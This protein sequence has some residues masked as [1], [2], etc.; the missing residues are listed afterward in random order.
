MPAYLT[1]ARYKKMAFGIDT[2]ELD[3]I[4]LAAL[5][6]QAT[7]MVNAYC[8]AP[9]L[10]QAH[11]FRGGT[12]T[13]EQHQ[14]RYPETPFDIGQRKAF[15]FHWPIKKMNQFRI[16]VTNTQYVGIDPTEL[17]VNNSLRY[18][19]VV[20][21]ALTSAGL[22]NALVIPNIGLATPVVR[23]A[24]D[25]GWDFIEPGE[26]LLPDDGQ[27]WRAQNQWWYSEQTGTDAMG[28][29]IGGAP[30]ITID[31][32]VATSG[33]TIDYDEGT[34]TLDSDMPPATTVEA[35]YHYKLPAEIQ[36][37]TGH[38]VTYLHA[39]GEMFARGMGHLDRMAIGEVSMARTRKQDAYNYDQGGGGS[40]VTDLAQ[41]VP[42][43][44][45]LLSSYRFDG[46]VVR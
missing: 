28:F 5:C 26:M 41:L 30:V 10:P 6:S 24:Y 8:L 7:T 14:W 19:E 39:E 12:V 16:Y 36:W 13:N 37:A 21:L 9:R 33:F 34:V 11:D 44:A 27:V 2:S 3:D 23:M 31:G 43:A 17:F 22:F 46:V 45:N 40:L 20:S 32:V 18:V 38:I 29:P 25:Y 4:E 15:P 1:P 42:E 35:A